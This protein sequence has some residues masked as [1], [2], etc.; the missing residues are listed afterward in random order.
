M[1]SSQ[2]GSYAAHPRQDLDSEAFPLFSTD[3][4]NVPFSTMPLFGT[5]V[6]L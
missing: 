2:I 1:K 4:T 5:V 3:E 6:T